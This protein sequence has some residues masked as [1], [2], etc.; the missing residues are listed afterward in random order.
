MAT[1]I[2]EGRMARAVVVVLLLIV[3]W[4]GR[5]SG[6]QTKDDAPEPRDIVGRSLKLVTDDGRVWLHAFPRPDGGEVWLYAEERY[7]GIRFLVSKEQKYVGVAIDSVLP[8]AIL[9]ISGES[10]M[11]LMSREDASP[12]LAVS[13]HPD[14]HGV[15]IMCDSSGEP[16]ARLPTT[17]RW[18]IDIE[19]ERNRD[20]ADNKP[21]GTGADK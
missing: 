6:A 16:I 7:G 9:G 4:L 19:S 11:L 10:P 18:P 3:F 13:E 20:G 1:A 15:A 2:L 5:I 8:R 14:G 17:A 12:I 21:G